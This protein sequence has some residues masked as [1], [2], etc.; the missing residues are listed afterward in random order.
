M[1]SSAK[2]RKSRRARLR[3]ILFCVMPFPTKEQIA[4]GNYPKWDRN[5]ED[6]KEILRHSGLPED[7]HPTEDEAYRLM[8]AYLED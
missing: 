4:L 1:A 6:E 2:K 8:I 7:Y 3:D 5:T